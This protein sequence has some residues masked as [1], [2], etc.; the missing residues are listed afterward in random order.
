MAKHEVFR[1]NDIHLD[2]YLLETASV[3]QIDRAPTELLKPRKKLWAWYLQLFSKY[4]K[5]VKNI[6]VSQSIIR[7]TF[8]PLSH[9]DG[10]GN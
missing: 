6:G 4:A 1:G 7:R 3:L 8:V 2:D 9:T 5:M 10:S